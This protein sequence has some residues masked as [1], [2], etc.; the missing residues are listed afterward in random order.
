MQFGTDIRH[1]TTHDKYIFILIKMFVNCYR[2]LRGECSIVI[3][4]SINDLPLFSLGQLFWT[5]KSRSIYII[6]RVRKSFNYTSNDE[7]TSFLKKIYYYFSSAT[8][9]S[10]FCDW[11]L[12]TFWCFLSRTRNWIKA[13][14]CY[15]YLR[16]KSTTIQIYKHCIWC[17]V[18][19][20]FYFGCVFV[21]RSNSNKN[22][23]HN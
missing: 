18:Y 19:Q 12:R 20:V 11:F 21:N 1:I 14:K 13:D 3:F 6:S 22:T 23:N 15:L 9:V 5:S 16:K 17:L 8:V 4:H 7:T 2:D 10:W